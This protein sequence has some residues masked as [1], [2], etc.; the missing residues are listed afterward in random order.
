MIHGRYSTVKRAALQEKI[1]AFR[2]DPAAGDLRSELA[3]LRALLQDYLDRFPDGVPLTSADIS[4][5]YGMIDGIG[6]LV[7]RIAKI[8]AMTALTQAELQLLQVTLIDAIKEFI[9]EPERQ[10]AFVSRI[11][12]TFGGRVGASMGS[13]PG[14][15]IITRDT[16]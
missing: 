5:I 15:N 6:R 13:L 2:A 4:N 12:G 9:P 16:E 1:E 14:A 7:E 11:A 3:I 8:L 10:R